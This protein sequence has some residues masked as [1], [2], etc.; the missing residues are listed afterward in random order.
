MWRMMLC[1]ITLTCSWSFADDPV[2]PAIPLPTI[3]GKTFTITDFGAV[4]D[5]KTL[6]TA[7]I[8]K[9]IDQCSK[10]GGGTVLV[11]AGKFLT[12]AFTLASSLNLKIDK[13]A[14]L[15]ISDNP[16][17]INFAGKDSVGCISANDCHDLSITGQGTIDG[18][19]QKWWAKYRNPKGGEDA[20]VP[21]RPFLVQI[22]Q[23]NRLLVEDVHLTNS[24][25][26]HL[27]PKLCQNVTIRNINVKAPA[28]APN[29]DGLDPS[30]WNYLIDH[31]TFD[32]GDD[33]IALK[34]N[35]QI[36]P[37]QPSC[38]NFTITNCTF[39]HGHGMSIGGQTN[40]GLKHMVVRDC[41]F[42]STEAG[43]R[44]K[45]G[46]GAGGLVE[47]ITCENITMKNVKNAIVITSYYPKGDAEPRTDPAQPVNATTPIW[48]HIRITNV[49]SEA[50]TNVGQILGLAE[51]P[52]SDVVLTNVSLAGRKG[53]E[54][55]N[56][57]GVHFEK[58][59][60]LMNRNSPP[61]IL[62]NADVTGMDPA[63]GN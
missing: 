24:P 7:A 31:C 54:I 50:G 59:Q 13:D 55:V 49:K 44:M 53:L 56:A 57:V 37:A 51:M 35:L 2:Q 11:P 46:R 32:V 5:G 22:M 27:V 63:T 38:Q 12:G 6:N 30:G 60:I 19:G 47:D 45:A 20:E 58:S 33:C 34:P 25:M 36:D 18:Q 29:T 41:T 15:L 43:I 61:L 4:A 9:T 40:G 52:V 3:P 14:T 17:D 16:A 26:F 1:A 8:Q 62:S 23:C 21:R 48:R 42:D 28:F 10:A 39:L